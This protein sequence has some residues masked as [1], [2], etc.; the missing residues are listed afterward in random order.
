MVLLATHPLRIAIL[1]AD[2]PM[3]ELEAQ[4]GRYGDMFDR[5]L[6]AG[7]KTA[8]LRLLCSHTGTLSSIRINTPNQQTLTPF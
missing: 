3:P 6:L 7:A 8:G 2:V 1:E 4:F 5:L